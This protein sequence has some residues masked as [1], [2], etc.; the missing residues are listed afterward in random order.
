APR[1]QS[2]VWREDVGETFDGYLDGG[3][4]SPPGS[5]GRALAH[6]A[7][8]RG[9][10]PAGSFVFV[11]SDFL[12]DPPSRDEWAAATAH[13]WDVVAVIV[14]DPVWEQ[15]FPLLGGVLVPVSD[16]EGSEVLG[17]RLS[18]RQ[19]TERREANE[20]RLRRL[21]DEL[22]LLG[23]DQVLLSDSSAA[24]IHRAF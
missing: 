20:E 24:E 22:T 11:V 3:F 23:I 19:A 15:S 7:V 21:R 18:D 2:Q 9:A 8:V 4:D 14:Q 12:A 16:A 6:L 13:G 17:V 1:A 10:V 5:L